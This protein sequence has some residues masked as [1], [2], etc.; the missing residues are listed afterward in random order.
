[1]RVD[2]SGR[3]DEP[4][5]ITNLPLLFFEAMAFMDALIIAIYPILLVW[6]WLETGYNWLLEDYL[7]DDP[8]TP[9]NTVLVFPFEKTPLTDA[10]ANGLLGAGAGGLLGLTGGPFSFI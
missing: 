3:E 8:E 4:A 1:M 10:I 5:G 6:A 9:G 2:P 7:V